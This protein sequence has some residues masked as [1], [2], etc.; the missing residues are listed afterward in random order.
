MKV[1]ITAVSYMNT[2][3]FLY[4][5][6]NGNWL[7]DYE[8]EQ[9]IPSQCARQLID[10]KTDISLIPVAAIPRVATPYL[11][12]NYCIGAVGKVHTV[13]L[14]SNVPV[15]EIERVYLDYQSLT[16]VNL[17]QIL[18]HKHWHIQP[19]WINASEGFENKIS[20]K[21]AGVVIGDRAFHLH[22]KFQY[23]FD[24]SEEWFKLTNLP[25]VFAAWV[26]NKQIP[27]EIIENFNK[28]LE[29]GLQN[30]DT[31]IEKYY[32]K[33]NNPD[34]NLKEYLTENIDF[35]L[36]KNKRKAI[37]LFYQYLTELKLLKKNALFI[38][39]RL[40]KKSQNKTL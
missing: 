40:S 11:V 30:I 29:F 36:D 17:V 31:A 38:R 39:Q 22:N 8:F 3:P 6:K 7:S 16:S 28:S 27:P 19:Q 2:L 15:A 35:R 24:L 25:F 4:G 20:G 5:I 37:K 1:K 13:L 14:V 34:I 33:I 26:A 10:N 9:K 18:A 12:S 32:G 21:T 23:V